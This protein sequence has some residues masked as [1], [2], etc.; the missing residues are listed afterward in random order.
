MFSINLESGFINWKNEIKTSI[1]PI[2]NGK[3]I[4]VLTKNGFL[5]LV[6]K[7]NGKVLR[8]KNLLKNIKNSSEIKTVGFILGKNS[9]YVTT[10]NGILIKVDVQSG[11]KKYIKKIAKSLNLSP[12]ISNDKL[13]ILSEDSKLYVYN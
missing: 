9:L 10:S 5:A 7:Y 11:K 2:I 8:S 6:D 13:Y 1:T 4:F 3:I 12:I